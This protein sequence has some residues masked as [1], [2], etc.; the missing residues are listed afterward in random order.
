[1][2][3]AI[4]FLVAVFFTAFS[5]VNVWAE[6]VS[7]RSEIGVYSGYA[8]SSTGKMKY[9]GWLPQQQ[10]SVVYEVGDWKFRGKLW[11]SASLNGVSD[12]GDETDYGFDITKKVGDFSANVGYVYLDMTGPDLHDLFVVVDFPK[13]AG[14][15]TPFVMIEDVLSAQPKV[16]E[17]GVL[18]KVG[19][20]AVASV[21]GQPFNLK[22][23]FG[24][25]DGAFGSEPEHPSIFRVD[26]GT[27]VK[28]G[29]GLTLTP[30]V[31]RQWTLNGLNRD[32]TF[33]CF[34]IG[35]VLPIK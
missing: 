28:V 1:M 14:V 16:M 24:G 2:R 29:D 10:L 3:K 31:R 7:I 22:G 17:G 18:Y 32:K 6:G 23:Y 35:Y 15:V 25:H 34:N 30:E 8:S 9:D 21:A 11:N 5:A 27:T 26:V 20:K 4:V 19:A 12:K 33:Y 13:V